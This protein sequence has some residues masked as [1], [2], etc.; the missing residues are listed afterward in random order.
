MADFKPVFTKDAAPPAGPYSQ[1]IVTSST[2]YCS[3]QI[4]CKPD[5]VIFT[6]P[7]YSLAQMT[8]LCIQNMN[9]VLKAAG[10][11]LE[12]VVKVNVYLTNMDDFA[13]MNGVYEK[14]F[15]H[16]PARSCVAVYQLPKGV[17]VEMECIALA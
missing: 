4:P 15:A 2:V 16:K 11:S 1:A 12:K 5:G 7:E 10:S 13:E 9:A 6:R 8:E 14:F 17:P 3:G